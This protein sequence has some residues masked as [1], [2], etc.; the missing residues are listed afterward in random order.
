LIKRSF[1][2]ANLELSESNKTKVLSLRVGLY[3]IGKLK[4]ATAP[5]PA[6]LL[7]KLTLPL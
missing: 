6:E 2:L 1:I 7:S 5:T 3:L 4:V